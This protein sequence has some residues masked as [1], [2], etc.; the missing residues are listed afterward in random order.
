MS[1]TILG[2]TPP[3]DFESGYDIR[4]RYYFRGRL[5]KTF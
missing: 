2:S 1:S 4:R 3:D 5:G